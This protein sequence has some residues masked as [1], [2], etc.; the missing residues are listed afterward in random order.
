MVCRD[1]KLAALL[2]AEHIPFTLSQYTGYT[3]VHR[4][5]RTHFIFF[6]NNRLQK[7]V[8]SLVEEKGVS[9]DSHG[10]LVQ[11]SAG[12]ATGLCLSESL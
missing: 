7:T 8:W 11:T 5:R 4:H 6:R 3:L 10:I 9:D 1:E 12:D 2:V